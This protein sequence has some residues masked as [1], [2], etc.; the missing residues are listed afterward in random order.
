MHDG[1]LSVIIV[2]QLT[3]K[4]EK[5]SSRGNMN[6]RGERTRGVRDIIIL[7]FAFFPFSFCREGRDFLVNHFFDVIIK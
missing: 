7:A 4:N 1:Y 5:K 2:E 6:L 3:V